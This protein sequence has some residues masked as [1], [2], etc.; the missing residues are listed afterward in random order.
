MRGEV[1]EGLTYH[2]NEGIAWYSLALVVANVRQWMQ[3]KQ[4]DEVQDGG[5]TEEK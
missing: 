3:D 2:W 4:I 1:G 5:E